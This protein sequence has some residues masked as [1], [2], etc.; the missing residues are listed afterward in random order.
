MAPNRH[1]HAARARHP[2]PPPLSPRL[3]PS[4]TPGRARSRGGGR[5]GARAAPAR[6]ATPRA[7]QRARG[8]AA[9]GLYRGGV[10][11]PGVQAQQQQQQ[12]QQ[13]AVLMDAGQPVTAGVMNATPAATGS[14]RVFI[15]NV[16]WATTSEEL[17]AVVAQ[18][19]GAGVPLSCEVA[20][21]RT[22]RSIGYAVAQLP[23]V[24]AAAAV[25]AALNDYELAGRRLVVREDRAPRKAVDSTTAPGVGKAC[26]TCGEVGH[27]K[28]DCPLGGD[29]GDGAAAPRR[30][31]LAATSGTSSA[32][33]RRM[34]AAR[35]TTHKGLPPVW[36]GG[37]HTS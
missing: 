13:Q 17:A 37:A 22:G 8:G 36:R 7:R 3:T 18:V 34:S 25:I 6:R 2:P 35:S 19:P 21:T 30:A 15:G 26:H 23:T 14:G 27:L 33:A 24:E 5:A 20:R 12:Q 32:N 11:G 9:A 10:G 31:T 4:P 16:A 1:P 29:G 28:R